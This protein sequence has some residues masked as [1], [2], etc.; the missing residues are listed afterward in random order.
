M[1]AAQLLTVRPHRRPGRAVIWRRRLVAVL[2][3]ASVALVAKA[4]VGAG[5]TEADPARAAPMIPA[6]ARSYVVRPGD[7]I[8]T[9]ARA[10]EPRGDVRPVVDRMAHGRQGRPLRVGERIVLP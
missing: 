3:L 4:W 7:T 1:S 8:W 9:I 6:S 10:L 5:W 2:A